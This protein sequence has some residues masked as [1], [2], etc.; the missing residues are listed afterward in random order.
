[1]VGSDRKEFV[2]DLTF[3]EKTSSETAKDFVEPLWARRKVG[4]LLDQIRVNGEKKE[5]IDEVVLLAKRYGIATPY[6]SYLVVPDAVM[7]VARPSGPGAPKGGFSAVPVPLP[8]A[9]G[10][11]GG[12]GGAG[13]GALPP[14]IATSTA[15][16]GRPMGAEDFAKLNAKADGKGLGGNRGD[17]AEKQV[18]EAIDKLKNETD[19]K[20]RA[21][22]M[23]TVKKL[24]E[25][26]E[27]WDEG[28]LRLKGAK[29]GYQTGR[30]GVN[31]AEAACNLRNQDRVTLTA[32]RIVNGRNCLELG[33]VWIDDAYKSDAK[34]VT[35]KAQS[36]AYFKI[37][38]KH[39]EMKDVFRLGNFLVWISPSGT[40]LVIDQNNGKDKLEDAEIAALFTK[41]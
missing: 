11:A 6:T 10:G 30:I 21:E 41:K 13:G 25:Q 22:M 31:L 15:P 20:A 32:N 37:L 19:P 36:D 14:G 18:R 7:P 12:F 28:N 2:Y 5:L 1:M 38:E 23:E 17:E 9:G 8:V 34:S 24:A 26:K 29:D 40:A 33:G 39:P 16:G 4:Y 27:T 3:P 35:V